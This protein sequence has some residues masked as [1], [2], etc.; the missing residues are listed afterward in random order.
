MLALNETWAAAND[1]SAI[2]KD[3]APNGYHIH[4]TIRPQSR[5]GHRGGGLALIVSNSMTSRVLLI[6]SSPTTFEAQCIKVTIIRCS[7]MIVNIYRPP[8]STPSTAFYHELSDYLADVC[9]NDSAPVVICGDFNCPGQDSHT[10][11]THLNDVLDSYNFIQQVNQPTR[12]NSILDIVA[13]NTLSFLSNTSVISSHHISDHSLITVHIN[14]NR[15]SL[16]TTIHQARPLHRINFQQLDN[17]ILK[18]SLITN[19]SNSVDQYTQRI[20]DVIKIELDKIAPL[21]NRRRVHKQFSC[22]NFLSDEAVQAKRYRRR[23]ERLWLRTGDDSIRQQYREACRTANKAINDSRSNYI[24][25]N[26]RNATGNSKTKWK[27]YSNLLHNKTV[28]ISQGLGENIFSFCNKLSDYFYDKILKT[29]L[30]KCC[31]SLQPITY[32]N[33]V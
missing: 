24:S 25:N 31:H 8:T 3:T 5:V 23:L 9:S 6:N 22:D 7:F 21:H 28:Q 20:N 15:P 19:S 16:Y 4:H 30:L 1:P 26:L 17:A 27:L 11:A 2:L 33:V 10:I 32:S 14:V 29:T 12:N 13:T 18:S